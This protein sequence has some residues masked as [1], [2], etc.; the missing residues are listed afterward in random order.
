MKVKFRYWNCTIKISKYLHGGFPAIHL[1]NPETK[2]TIATA[3]VNLI[4][5]GII[6]PEHHCYLKDYAEN[7]GIVQIL[8]EAGAVI[9]VRQINFG[10]SNYTATLC[11]LSP[12]LIEQFQNLSFTSLKYQFN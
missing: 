7:Y 4:D 2:E 3:T 1:I 12:Q 5:Y 11:Q 10:I 8:T 9:P 6:P